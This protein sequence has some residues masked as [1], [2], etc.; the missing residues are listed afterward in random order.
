LDCSIDWTDHVDRLDP[1]KMVFMVAGD[2]D[3]KELVRERVAYVGD[4][5]E[6]DDRNILSRGTSQQLKAQLLSPA[7]CGKGPS[8]LLQAEEQSHVSILLVSVEA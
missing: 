7:P 3:T 2:Q 1:W 4:L 8:K 5:R 6:V